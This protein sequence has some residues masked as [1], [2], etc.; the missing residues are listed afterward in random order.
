MNPFALRSAV[1]M[2][3]IAIDRPTLRCILLVL[4]LPLT[5]SEPL[6]RSESVSLIL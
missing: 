2:L 6:V 3:T 1:A 4:S 5:L